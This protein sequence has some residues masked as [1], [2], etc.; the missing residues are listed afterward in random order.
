M[1]VEYKELMLTAGGGNC[2]FSYR[3]QHGS[4]ISGLVNFRHLRVR[5]K[6]VVDIAQHI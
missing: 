3:E 2:G 4:F 6:A 5:M 1:A